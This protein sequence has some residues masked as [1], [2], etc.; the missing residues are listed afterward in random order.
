MTIRRQTDRPRSWMFVPGNKQRFLEKAAGSEADAVLLD[1]ED[2]VLPEDKQQGREMIA[3]TLAAGWSGPLL[4]VRVNALS[5]PWL[6]DDLKAIVGPGLQ[7]I[8]LT[9]VNG[10]DEVREVSARLARL[11]AERGLPAGSVR[12]MAAIESAVG[13]INAHAVACADPR[14]SALIFGAEDYALDLGLSARRE[15]EAAELIHARSTIVV[16]AAAAQVWSVD[17]VFPNLD[18]PDGLLKDTIQAR[19][20]GFTAKSTFNPRQLAD[21]N[22][23]FSPQP[24]ELEYAR[25]VADA[26]EQ[27]QQRGDASV[28]VGG[29]LVD[30]PILLR[31]LAI[32]KTQEA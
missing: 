18:D 32:L 3:A 12:I 16:A 23:I 13:L 27:A 8:C 17:G 2:G 9:K 24:E 29:Q 4:Y 25:K 28:A 31:A 21:L 14:V 11:E 10:A 26:F 22:R 6:D 15:G 19:R 1:L 30:R 7:G 5:T 20:L